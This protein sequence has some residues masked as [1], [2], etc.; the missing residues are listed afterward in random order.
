MHIN[1]IFRDAIVS[2]AIFRYAYVFILRKNLFVGL[3]VR[4]VRSIGLFSRSANQPA[5]MLKNK[6]H[7]DEESEQKSP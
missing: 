6:E 2:R 3:S 5:D 1:K 7:D 4:S